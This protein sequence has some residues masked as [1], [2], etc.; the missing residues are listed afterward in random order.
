MIAVAMRD[1][2]IYIS[3]HS[4]SAKLGEDIVCA[5]V[6]VLLQTLVGSIEDLTEDKITYQLTPGNGAVEWENLSERG[7]FLVD[8]FFVGISAIINTCPD[9]VKLI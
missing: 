7:K 6:S 1:R 2:S 5:S 3:G 9:Y 4:R 8:S